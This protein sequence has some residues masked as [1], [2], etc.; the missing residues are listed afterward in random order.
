[1]KFASDN[2]GPVHPNVMQALN[3]ANTGYAKAYGDDD[4]TAAVAQDLRTLFEAPNAACYLVPI[5]TAANSLILATLTKPWETIFCHA[6]SHIHEDE[7]NAPEF[8]TGGAKLTLVPGADAKMTAETLETAILAEETRGLHGPQRGP[9]S[10]TQITERGTIYSL[11]EIRAITDVAHKYG[12][13][14][15]MDGARFA[16]ACA[17][18]NCSAAEM[19][20]KAG[21]DAVSFGGTKNGLMAVEAAI[22]FDPEYAWEFELRRK[23]GAHLFSKQRF[24][25]A[26]M[27]AYVKDDLWLELAKSANGAMARMVRGL[28][29]NPNVEIAFEPRGNLVF[30]SW[31]RHLHQKLYAA[32]AY[33]YIMAGDHTQGDPDEMLP[34]RLVMDWSATD[35][36]VDRFLSILNG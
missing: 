1:M 12:L 28:K 33:Y 22:F 30:A 10:I 26:Q 15:H 4:Y 20:W 17:A 24:L 23:R 36:A 8:Y 19:S 9:V 25:A 7:C 14:T 13:K 27:Q 16:N 29:Q 5:G 11:D 6:V 21:I 31:P 18:L 2:N 32:G 34:A 3:D 35:D